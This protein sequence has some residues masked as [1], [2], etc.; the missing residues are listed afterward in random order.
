M[1]ATDHRMR[2]L[3]LQKEVDVL[4]VRFWELGRA[5]P[6]TITEMHGPG[7]LYPFELALS[8]RS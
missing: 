6:G 8:D 7:V 3:H 4:I 5:V 2:G 1:L